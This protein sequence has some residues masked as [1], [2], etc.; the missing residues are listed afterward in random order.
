MTFG[1]KL[2]QQRESRGIHLEEIAQATKIGSRYLRA[3]EHDDFDS[4]PEDVFTKGFVRAVAA[5]IGSDPDALVEEYVRERASR[6]AAAAVTDTDEVVREMSRVLKVGESGEGWRLPRVSGKVG[7]ASAVL[8]VLVLAVW[9]VAARR[10]GEEPTAVV[11]PPPLVAE[12]VPPIQPGVAPLPQHDVADAAPGPPVSDVFERELDA[13]SPG[14]TAIEPPVVAPPR[15]EP[16]AAPALPPPKSPS[17]KPEDTVNLPPPKSPAAKPKDAVKP[18]PPKPASVKPAVVAP[19]PP[20]K[21]APAAPRKPSVAAPPAAMIVS[22]AGLGTDVVGRGLVGQA[23]RFREGS[24]V[25][26]WTRVLRGKPG[27]SIRHVWIYEGR[28]VS[29]VVLEIG[30]GNWSTQSRRHLQPGSIGGWAVEARD[31]SGRVLARQAFVCQGA[32]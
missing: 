13:E 23:E 30:S 7:A 32:N 4:L 18:P 20:P 27:E 10:R 31:A 12:R 1:E 29:A 15:V 16:R 22:E 21:P 25:W 8:V 9:W 14:V 2:R 5:H 11:T 3:L 28:E 6:I 17:L 26:F 19:A 24:D